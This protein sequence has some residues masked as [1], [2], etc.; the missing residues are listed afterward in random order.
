MNAS[1]FYGL[2]GIVVAM[3][4]VI[5][6]LLTAFGSFFTRMPI[7]TGTGILALIF[8][9]TYTL[10]V[11]DVSHRSGHRFVSTVTLG[12]IIKLLLC[13]SAVLIWLLNV[14]KNLNKPDLFFLMGV[15]TIFSIVESAY[16]AKFTRMLNKDQEK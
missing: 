14:R 2:F 13:I 4:L 10:T 1:R 8:L 9:L 7:L 16:L 15:Y 12:T 6:F 3:V 5:G 11:R